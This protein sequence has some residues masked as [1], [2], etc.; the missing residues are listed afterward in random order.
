M[1]SALLLQLSQ[2]LPAWLQQTPPAFTLQLS[3]LSASRISFAWKSVLCIVDSFQFEILCFQLLHRSA[4][5]IY[6]PPRSAGSASLPEKFCTEHGMIHG[7]PAQSCEIYGSAQNGQYRSRPIS[8]AS[9]TSSPEHSIFLAISH[10]VFHH[11]I[12]MYDLQT[13]LFILPVVFIQIF[14]RIPVFACSMSII[15]P[16]FF[17]CSF[18]SSVNTLYL[19]YRRSLTNST[20]FPGI[21]NL[22]AAAE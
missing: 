16:P 12:G 19:L 9:S 22:L 6:H 8:S 21:L 14:F 7:S 20:V 15:L 2:R 17:F 1:R 4:H 5:Q 18:C 11:A 3:S 13:D 10:C